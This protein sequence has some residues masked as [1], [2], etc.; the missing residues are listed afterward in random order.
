M[1]T[2]AG[3]RRGRNFTRAKLS[4]EGEVMPQAALTER[5]RMLK[6]DKAHGRVGLLDWS[7]KVPEPKRGP[8]DF[9]TFPFQRELYDETAGDKELVVKKA[10]QVGV[11]TFMLRWALYWADVKGLT[12]LYVFP[13]ATDVYDFSDARIKPAI[14]GSEYLRG[15]IP[16]GLVQNKGLKAVG[17]GFVYFRGSE[18]KRRLDSV[19]ADILAL[20]EYDTLVQENIGDAERRISGSL[21]GLI[22]RIGVPSLTDFGIEREWDRSDKRRWFVKC[23]GCGEQQYLTFDNIAWDHD[24]RDPPFGAHLVCGK[25]GKA[26]ID[27]LKG[28]WVPEHPDVDMRGYHMPRM[29]VKHADLDAIV[30]ASLRKEPYMVQV[31]RNK[32]LAEPDDGEGNRLT[33]EE[34]A[35]AQ[36]DFARVAGY[37]GMNTVTM[38]VDVASTRALTVRISEHLDLQTRRCLW[39]GEVDSFDEVALLMERYRVNMACIDHLPEH[40]LAMGLAERFPG[41]VYLVG[42]AQQRDVLAIEPDQRRVMVRRTEMLDA[43]FEQIRL[44]RNLLPAD[45]PETYVAEMMSPVR[46]VERDEFDRVTVRYVKTG[47]ADDYAMC[48]GYDMIASEV[49]YLRQGVDEIQRDVLHRLEDSLE[50]RRSALN[51]PENDYYYSEGPDD[52]SYDLDRLMSSFD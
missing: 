24:R 29:I 52:G 17:L 11:S 47:S 28:E 36:R 9:V 42:F 10:T 32:D 21:V 31:H 20:D 8:L 38:G 40:R 33:R 14:D 51:D 23:G 22:R 46:K 7:M 13:T 25:C 48:E 41:R 2:A 1:T 6:T 27:V 50:F 44:Q 49:W 16:P 4:E 15:R 34:I 43:T 12:C 19:D 37:D 5:L 45:L 18:S 35:A 3:Q 39:V 26:R 30:K